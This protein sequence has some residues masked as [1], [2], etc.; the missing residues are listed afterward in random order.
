MKK[1]MLILFFTILIFISP[2][3]VSAQNIIQWWD[4]VL[5][6]FHIAEGIHKGEGIKDNI[7]KLLREEMPDIKQPRIF[8]SP[9]RLLYMIENE[10]NICNPSMKK[11]PKREECMYFSIPCIFLPGVGITI[12]KNDYPLFT[13]KKPS[14][15]TLLNNSQLKLGDQL[16]RKYGKGI[17][18]LLNKYQ[19]AKHIYKTKD[20]LGY[21]KL[22]E[23]MLLN[24]FDYVLGYAVEFGYIGQKLGKLD[25]LQF[26]PLQEARPYTISY[27][28]CSKTDEGK[29]M[30]KRIN[31]ILIQNRPTERYRSFTEKWL[32]K[33]LIPEYRKAYDEQF[34]TI[35]E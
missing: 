30:I 23:M 2:D 20:R 33:D 7:L 1:A 17:D 26:L 4:I 19:D 5:P 14:L 13:S 25:Q 32:D 18:P 21:E 34:L 31:K 6:P 27:I 22:V 9:T 29:K 24:R 12:R 15:N 3:K 16:N 8:S 10:T 11:T 28:A 35:V